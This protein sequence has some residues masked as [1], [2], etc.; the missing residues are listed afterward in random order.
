MRITSLQN[1]RIKDVVKLHQHKQRQRQGKLLIEGYRTLLHAVEQ[2][3]LIAELYICP[4]LF[5]GKN[6]ET[7]IRRIAARGASVFDVTEEPFRK[8]AFR[9]RCEGLLAV[10]P[11]I[12]RPLP[13]Q[14]PSQDAFYLIAE[15]IE[16]PGNLGTILRSADGA[17]ANGVITLRSMHRSLAPGCCAWQRRRV[18]CHAG[19]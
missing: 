2:C 8:M 18:L 7:L 15:G 19:L 14:Q 16:K 9:P 3:Y 1:P 6:E 5:F 13:A 10:A 12:R 11:Q 17:G 4:S